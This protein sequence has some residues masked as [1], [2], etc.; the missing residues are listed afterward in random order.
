MPCFPLRRR[1]NFA[2]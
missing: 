1:C 2:A